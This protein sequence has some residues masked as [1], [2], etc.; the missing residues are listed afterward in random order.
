MELEMEESKVTFARIAEHSAPRKAAPRW[1]SG[2]E[3]REHC[4]AVLD[5][6]SWPGSE[7]PVRTLGLTS[8]CRGEGVSTLAA[9]LAMTAASYD[10]GRVL[11]VD[12]DLAH[13]SVAA[14]FGAAACPGLAECLR[15]GER[16]GE[17]FAAT[18][19]EGLWVLPAGR[20]RGSPASAFG[21]PR[22]A[23]L[24][25]DLAGRFALTVFDL[26]PVNQAS[27][28]GAIAPLLDGVL[29]V[30]EAERVPWE[31]VQRAKELLS[32]AEANVLGAVLNKRRDKSPSWML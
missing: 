26:P 6:C 8:C 1:K 9:H 22:L 19:V 23:E 31:A 25:H 5:Q 28:M 12:C 24:V 11:L 21:S 15:S 27:C 3:V 7:H 18:P 16:D 20:L 32:R 10:A 4:Q 30:I 17:L 29:L 13:P 14:R 2:A